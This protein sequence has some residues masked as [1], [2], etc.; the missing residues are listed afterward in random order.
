MIRRE[1]DGLA[2]MPFPQWLNWGWTN[3]WEPR[4]CIFWVGPLGIVFREFWVKP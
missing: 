3:G 4:E 2:Y 1:Y